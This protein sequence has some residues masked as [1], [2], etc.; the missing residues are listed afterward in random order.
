MPIPA[1]FFNTLDYIKN[2]K[3][4]R[5]FQSE[6]MKIFIPI[7]Q[8]STMKFE[9]RTYNRYLKLYVQSIFKS[10]KEIMQTR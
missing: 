4:K 2:N 1:Q 3:V 8:K 5:Y 6:S 7:M 9:V 10:K